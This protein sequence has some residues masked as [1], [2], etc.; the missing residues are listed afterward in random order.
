MAVYLHHYPASLFSEKIR[1]LLGYLK[2]EW[3]SVTISPVMPRPLLM[4]LT[5]GYRRTPVLQIGANVYCDTSV[6]AK[7]L[8]REFSD[9]HLY[10]HGF[11]ANRLAEWCDNR[12]FEVTVA[13]NFSPQAL[14][15]MMGQFSER[16]REAF[17]A[18]REKLSPPESRGKRMSPEAASQQFRYYLSEL[19][20]SLT[21][22]F[23]FGNTPTIADFSLYHCLW[24]INA[25]PVNRELLSPHQQLGQWMQRMVVLADQAIAPI[26]STAERALEEAGKCSPVLPSLDVSLPTGFNVGDKV[27]VKPMDYGIVPVHGVLVSHSDDEIV[28]SRTDECAGELFVHFPVLGFELEKA[29]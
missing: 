12:L 7:A 19:D 16:A 9:G 21:C 20:S 3:H 23:L 26:E 5:G 13:L 14:P 28:I 10:A 18:D 6:I 4:P 11:N 22:E 1:L 17:F 8:D 25:N 27:S 29:D 2:V 15:A 24:F